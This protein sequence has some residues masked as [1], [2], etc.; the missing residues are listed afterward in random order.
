MKIHKFAELHQAVRLVKEFVELLAVIDYAVIL[1]TLHLK[2][3]TCY[4]ACNVVDREEYFWN[5]LKQ[6]EEV[7]TAEIRQDIQLKIS[8]RIFLNSTSA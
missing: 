6:L 7:L 4:A 3:S 1:D 5:R 8:R 2:G